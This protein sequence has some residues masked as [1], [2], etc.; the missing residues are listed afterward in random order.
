MKMALSIEALIHDGFLKAYYA[1]AQKAAYDPQWA[2]ENPLLFEVKK[3]NGSF[4][5]ITN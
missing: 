3:Q 1:W 4:V 2:E 5:V